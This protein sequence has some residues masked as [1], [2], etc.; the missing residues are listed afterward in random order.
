VTADAD[1][2]AR[3][4][5]RA[6]SPFELLRFTATPVPGALVVVEI[7]GRVAAASG[8]FARRPVLVVEAGADR[9][10]LEL[11]PARATLVDDRWSATYAIPAESYDAARFAL[12]LRGTLL[13]LPHPDEPTDADRLTLL[14]REA[15][16]L[17]R[18][19]EAAERDAADARSEATATAGEL[20][21]A[22]SAARDGALA[23]SADRI[24][25]L[26]QEL[27]EARAAHEAAL[28]DVTAEREARDAALAEARANHEAALAERTAERD[29]RDVALAEAR[30]AHEAAL[31]ERTAERDAAL[32]QAA[33]ERD[34][35]RARDAAALD[36]AQARAE[37]AEERAVL[38]ER[39]AEAA[40]AALAQADDGQDAVD[41]QRLAE[42]EARARAAAEGIA[43]LRAELAEERER[44]QARTDE[45]PASSSLWADEDDTDPDR[46]QV[47][48][49][50]RD[51]DDTRPLERTP[52]DEPRPRDEPTSR[53][54]RTASGE[55]L[56]PLERGALPR[57][58]HGARGVGAWVAV[59]ALAL[60]V[61]VLLGLLLGFLV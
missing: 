3:S 46:T 56:R 7:E 10:R 8:R 43:V 16:A 27:A 11:A 30:A 5:R 47:L 55:T 32:A 14:A 13:D 35:A 44:A 52:R 53:D 60:F 58:R 41:A 36:E 4:S 42:A 38:A 25:A 61:F 1:A 51:E 59:A 21:A 50:V 23:E 39:R 24:A 49:P 6:R 57:E 34:A 19:L 29:A 28:A 40:E 33:E 26:E 18:Q 17:R 31:A 45:P 2:S 48:S 22:V 54:R 37:A 12:G 20:G 15:N 9:P